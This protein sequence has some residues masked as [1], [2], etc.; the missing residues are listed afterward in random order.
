MVLA[1]HVLWPIHA[2]RSAVARLET[3][4]RKEG[5]HSGPQSSALKPQV[6]SRAP[7]QR[8]GDCD[9]V[10][11]AGRQACGLRRGLHAYARQAPPACRWQRGLLLSRARLLVN[12]VVDERRLSCSGSTS[13]A[14][15]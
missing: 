11:A 4:G 7:V 15:T 1:G 9:K 13:C 12:H 5:I 10:D 3:A 14:I 2:G 6:F 8:L